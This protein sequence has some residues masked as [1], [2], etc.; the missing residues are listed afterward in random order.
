MDAS[1]LT[2]LLC[3]TVL[4]LES[5][6][7]A[8][9]SVYIIT[10]I[11]LDFYKQKN[12]KTGNKIRMALGLSN[13]CL[14]IITFANIFSGFL[15]PMTSRMTSSNYILYSFNMYCISACCWFRAL[16]S[17]FYFIKIVKVKTS[18][19]MWV[20][21]N[22]SPIV[23]WVILV[24]QVVSFGSFITAFFLIVPR[25]ASH[26]STV[27]S[28]KA[29]DVAELRR[30]F[31]HIVIVVTFL[32]LLTILV[33]SITTV[34][35]LGKHRLK[36]VQNMGPNVQLDTYNR[37]VFRILQSL[38]FFVMFFPVMLIFYLQVSEE[39]SPGFWVSLIALS[40]FPPIQAMFIILLNPRLKQGWK[41]MIKHVRSQQ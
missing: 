39:M 3:V 10:F 27:S 19:F 15:W 2:S 36:M 32:P 1:G 12:I 7:A 22:I 38:F 13:V 6:V 8:V 4:V 24:A 9:A 37:A 33:T 23:S 18:C 40:A 28:S 16:L 29:A 21:T 26:N 20:K 30:T 5:S 17:F 34:V 31:I 11:L 14:T 25:A 35:V 41:E